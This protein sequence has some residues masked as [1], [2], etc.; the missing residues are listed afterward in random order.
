MKKLFI[1][2]VFVL[3]IT[4]ASSTKVEPQ[5]THPPIQEQVQPISARIDSINIKAV[6][7]QQL[8]QQL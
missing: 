8:I 4:G 5:V 6:Q 3:F 2:P 1:L 7:L